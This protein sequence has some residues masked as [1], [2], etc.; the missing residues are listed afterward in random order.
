[1]A[2]WAAAVADGVGGGPA[3]DVASAAIVHRLAAGRLRVADE[4]ELVRAVRGANW[5]L[6]AHT[7]RNPALAGMATTLTGIVT[8]P[9]GTGLL[10]MHSGDS[11]AYRLRAGILSRQS[12]DDSLVQALVDNGVIDA[13]DAATHPRRNIVTASLSGFV[14]DDVTVVAADALPGDRWLLCSDGLTDYLPEALVA[15]IVATGAPEEAATALVR[16]ALRAGTRDNV[17]AVVCDV[18][19]GEADRRDE[20]RFA[21]AAGVRFAER[22]DDAS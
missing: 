22:L 14:D 6:W 4:S 8:A 2:P 17:T 21:G 16:T 3:G 20:A 5:E 13:R 1:V 10:L 12:R 19:E 7:R 9:S 18:V 15:E 11:R